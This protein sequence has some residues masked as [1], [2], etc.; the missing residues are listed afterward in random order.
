VPARGAP[1]A[2]SGR[3]LADLGRAT[4]GRNFVCGDGAGIGRSFDRMP[5]IEGAASAA[6]APV[7][8]LKAHPI[9]FVLFFLI[10]A[11]IAIRFRKQIVS[12]ISGV[13]IAGRVAGIAGP[14]ATAG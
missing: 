13:P 5:R 8:W 9:V 1:A 3:A 4:D 11:L 14:A 10:L 12:L 6:K 2:R 7:G